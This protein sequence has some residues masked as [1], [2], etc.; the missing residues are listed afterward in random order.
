MPR[1]V[2]PDLPTVRG[3]VEAELDRPRGTANVVELWTTV[4][5]FPAYE[6]SD[7]GNVRSRRDRKVKAVHLD[8]D[9]VE[10]VWLWRD[11]R[12]VVRAVHRL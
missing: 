12:P 11:G 8:A 4:A 3:A 5:E 10:S 9:G 7:R 2:V 6:I 1:H